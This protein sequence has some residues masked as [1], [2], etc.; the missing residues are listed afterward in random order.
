MAAREGDDVLGVDAV[1]R[2]GPPDK[3]GVGLVGAVML[4]VIAAVVLL[5]VL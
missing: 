4:A 1:G 5:I 3:L 2:D